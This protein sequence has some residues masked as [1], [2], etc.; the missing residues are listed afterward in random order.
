MHDSPRHWFISDTHF[1]A[2]RE[3]HIEAF[4]RLCDKPQTGDTIVLLGDIFEI[5]VTD[6]LAAESDLRIE[7]C[8]KAC[9][10]RGIKVVF[11]HGNRDF[12]VGRRFYE[13]T[14]ASPLPDPSTWQLP[15]GR[16]CILT[17]G[18][19]FCTDDAG[20]RRYRKVVRNKLF[21]FTFRHLPKATRIKIAKSIRQS[22]LRAHEKSEHQSYDANQELIESYFQKFAP[23]SILLMGHTHLP[24]LHSNEK[25]HRL[26]LG[27]WRDTLWYA[28]ASNE[29]GIELFEADL[30][31][32][33]E[34]LRHHLP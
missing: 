24:M 8:I 21:Q 2:H 34:S 4:E 29:E 19:W 18:D 12:M 20:Y 25:H 33:S 3:A 28:V 23:I 5:W 7:R 14:G 13:R 16:S 26:V 10:D 17:H 22:S 31:L 1:C 9:V 11:M 30:N 32:R 15:D 6:D 27:D